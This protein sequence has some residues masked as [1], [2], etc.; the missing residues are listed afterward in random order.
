ML[1]DL[2]RRTHW[3]ERCRRRTPCEIKC[4]KDVKIFASAIPK[5]I[6]SA[7]PDLLGHAGSDPAGMTPV[8][9]VQKGEK[10]TLFGISRTADR[11]RTFAVTLSRP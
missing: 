1:S 8:F 5:M 3:T 6:A 2:D 10:V 7:I 9:V 4:F 11:L